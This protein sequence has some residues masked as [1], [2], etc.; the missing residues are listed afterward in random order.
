MLVVKSEVTHTSSCVL[1]SGSVSMARTT[2]R[3]HVT[4]DLCPRVTFDLSASSQETNVWILFLP[5]LN[6][7]LSEFQIPTRLTDSRPD[8]SSGLGAYSHAQWAA[9]H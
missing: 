9:S 3:R 4:E 7:L 1:N 2:A 5:A 8:Q 6:S